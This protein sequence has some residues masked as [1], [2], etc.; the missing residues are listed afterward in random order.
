V[1]EKEL[2]EY[3]SDE[4]NGLSQSTIVDGVEINVKYKPT[5][6]LILQEN[7]GSIVIPSKEY[8]KLNQKYSNYHYFTLSLSKNN[9][10]ALY[11]NSHAYSQFSELVQTLSFRMPVHTNLTTSESDTVEVLDYV[12]PRTYGMGAATSLLFVF[13]K[14]KIQNDEWLQFN[15]AEFGMGLGRQSF[16][17]RLEDIDDLPQLKF[18]ID[19]E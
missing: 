15:L 9:K 10:E 5:S 13:D 11:A 17:F 3:I 8:D 2:R 1:N 7:R 16:R 6:L 18:K 14:E 4:S 12:F 19:Q